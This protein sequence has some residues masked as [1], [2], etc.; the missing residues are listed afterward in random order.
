MSPLVYSCDALSVYSGLLYLSFPI[1]VTFHH[2]EHSL[3]YLQKFSDLVNDA[4][5]FL[6]G[7]TKKWKNIQTF[8]PA[9][10]TETCQSNEFSALAQRKS[11]ITSTVL[12][13]LHVQ[14]QTG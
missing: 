4:V 11:R 12:L 6:S 3:T 10:F 13:L 2:E 7:K 5:N 8:F 9:Q 14:K 1:T